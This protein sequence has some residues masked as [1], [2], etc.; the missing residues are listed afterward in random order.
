[1][2]A[3]CAAQPQPPTTSRDDCGTFELKQGDGLPATAIACIV[4][5]VRDGRAVRLQETRP[6]TEG[7]PIVSVYATQQEGWVLVIRDTTQDKFGNYGVVRE[8]CWEP[9][10]TGGDLMF[11]RCEPA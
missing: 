3:G 8:K 9:R 10:S 1:M 2:L 4:D 7:D 5:A 6:T 11:E